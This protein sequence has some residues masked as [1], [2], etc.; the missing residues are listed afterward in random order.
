[1]HDDAAHE[2]PRL[3]SLHPRPPCSSGR[4]QQALWCVKL[5]SGLSAYADQS[6]SQFAFAATIL[7][8]LVL[9]GSS[10]KTLPLFT[11]G[12]TRFG[13]L[14]YCDDQGCSKASVGYQPSSVT[15]P[16][17]LTYTLVL[18][19]PLL[20]LAFLSTIL[21]LIA[22]RREWAMTRLTSA[23]SGLAA[24]VGVFVFIFDFALFAVAKAWLTL[25]TW[26][27]LVL[28][29]V[30]FI[31]GRRSVAARRTRN[32]EKPLD[33]ELPINEERAKGTLKSKKSKSKPVTLPM[34]NAVEEQP[35]NSEHTRAGSM[36]TQPVQYPPP[37]STPAFA[38]RREVGLPVFPGG[39]VQ[40]KRG[41]ENGLPAFPEME[42]DQVT[43][44]SHSPPLR[45]RI[46]G[47]HVVAERDI[48]PKRY[49]DP[50]SSSPR[51]DG[52]I[53]GRS[54]FRAVDELNPR[55]QSSGHTIATP[56]RA[57]NPSPEHI[58]P[59]RQGSDPTYFTSA[60]A[61]QTRPP[62]P[63]V[64]AALQ[65][66]AGTPFQASSGTPPFMHGG[67]TPPQMPSPQHYAHVPPTNQYAQPVEQPE[68]RPGFS[69][70][71]T[72]GTAYYTPGSFHQQYPSA[73]AAVG[74]DYSP[75]QGQHTPRGYS[76][77]QPQTEHPGYP[78]R[79]SYYIPPAFASDPYDPEGL[80]MPS[81]YHGPKVVARDSAYLSSRL[82]NLLDNTAASSRPPPP[83]G[84]TA[85]PYFPASHTPPPQINSTPPLSNATPPALPP[86]P[87]ALYR[88]AT[89]SNSRQSPAIP[90]RLPPKPI[91]SPDS[92]STA[93][94]SDPSARTSRFQHDDELPAYEDP[95]AGPSEHRGA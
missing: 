77:H 92:V 53:P 80:T 59:R 51:A 40:P 72:Q 18:H 89:P 29:S 34:P 14:G 46:V 36:G 65:R 37:A 1:V 42:L 11:A 4:R 54:G 79:Q 91:G 45:A 24:I 19:I 6:G 68:S 44:T 21:G 32:A 67:Y 43:A 16:K 66:S 13:P 48:P 41:P 15:V 9:A 30:L 5:A 64:P 17:W 81:A 10:L 71:T 83:T 60:F 63:P 95:L 28:A 70:W 50:Q 62:V 57:S 56:Y 78:S 87:P 94:K 74:H 39:E 90:P 82:D 12:S 33:V 25:A 52:Y 2:K 3:W 26:L 8:A 93:V 27:L 85:S 75:Q 49:G 38:P 76:E 69:Q 22:H 31:V 73:P 47:D 58:A 55:R 86:K 88:E 7:S 84:V 20:I 23:T 61:T 35:L